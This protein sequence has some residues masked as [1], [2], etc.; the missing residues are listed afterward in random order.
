MLFDLDTTQGEWFNFFSSHMNPTTG[1]IVYDEPMADARVRIR[2]IA[3]FLEERMAKR[4]KVV[5]N[6]FNP[7]T[8]GM[9]RMSY[10]PDLSPEDAQAEREDMY[11]YAIMDIENFKNSKTGEVIECTRENKLAL[12]KV[13]VFDRF[14]ARCFQIIGSSGVKGKEEAEK[15]S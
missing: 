1:E 2:S 9:E 13:P 4:K 8:R 15:N 7:K 10:V 3:P 14:V 11:D 12:M 5:E 6:V